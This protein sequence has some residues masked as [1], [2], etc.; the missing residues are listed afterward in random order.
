MNIGIIGGEGFVGSGIRESLQRKNVTCLSIKRNNY[1]EVKGSSFD[2]LINANG[3][4]KKYLAAQSP[5]EEFE[6][7]VV[8]V[9]H[10]LLDFTFRSY[11]HCSSVDVYP[12]HENPQR[13]TEASP[14]DLRALSPYGFHKYLAEQ[15]VQRYA[16]RW[17]ILRFGGFVGEGLK[18]NSL[19]DMLHDVPLRV[20]VDSRYQYLPTTEAGEVIWSLL[21]KQISNEIFNVC[22]NGCIS[23]REAAA[24]VPGY[25]ARYAVEQPA[26]EQYDVNIDKLQQFCK[27]PKTSDSVKAFMR[28]YQETA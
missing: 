3:N 20:H 15:L 16:K 23:L 21:S 28:A 2:V 10:S 22:G 18:K 13:N 11:V 4:S 6:A 17:L 5:K 7:S 9:Q 8:S 25:A 1:Q 27:V 24:S 19:Y 14:L 12:D 26:V